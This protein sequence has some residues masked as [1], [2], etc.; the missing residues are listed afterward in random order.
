MGSEHSHAPAAIAARLRAGPRPSYL[1]DAVYGGIDGAVTT[2]A[3]VSGVE[4]AGL[5]AGVI[6]VLGLANLVGDGLSMAA[7]SYSGTRTE[8]HELEH[9]EAMER[10]HIE[11]HPEGERE[12]VRQIYAAKGLTGDELERVVEAVTADRE[13]WVSTMLV[14]EHGLALRL[15]SPLRAAATTFVAFM[16][17]GSVPLAPYVVGWLGSGAAV[18]PEDRAGTFAL[19]GALTGV[20]FFLVGALRVRWSVRPWWALGLGTLVVGTLAAAAAWG[21][22]RALAGLVA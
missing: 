10:R 2:F 6:L 16:L 20:V 4:G 1:R 22:G 7:G 21:I 11:R 14:E 8:A 3:V 9:Y 12:E 18:A 15:R 13:R 17:C 5:Q 19:T